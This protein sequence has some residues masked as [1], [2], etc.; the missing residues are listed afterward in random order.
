MTKL[1]LDSIGM[2][3]T[4]MFYD[5]FH[6]KMNLEKSLLST[7]K[8]LKPYNDIMFTT[9]DEDVLSSIY[10]QTITTCKDSNNSVMILRKLMKTKFGSIYFID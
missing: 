7:L 1:T 3:D 10:T 2:Y 4:F 8:I 5:H 6:L 9:S